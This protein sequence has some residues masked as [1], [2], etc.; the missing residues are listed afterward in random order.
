MQ[1]E[2]SGLIEYVKSYCSDLNL[3]AFLANLRRLCREY[4]LSILGVKCTLW[5]MREKCGIDLYGDGLGLVPYYYEQC[6]KYFIWRKQMKEQ[7]KGYEPQEN[8]VEFVK[9]DG[10]KDDVFT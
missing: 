10:V 7:V 3:T 6:K 5:Y 4:D 8:V 1:D 9:N 2:M